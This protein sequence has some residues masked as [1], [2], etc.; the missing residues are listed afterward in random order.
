MALQVEKVSGRLRR[1]ATEIC[2]R[3][4][5]EES[6]EEKFKERITQWGEPNS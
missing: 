1:S 6:N 4:C 3:I 5:V 2:S